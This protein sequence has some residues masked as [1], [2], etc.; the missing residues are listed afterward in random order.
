[1]ED[2]NHRAVGRG[3][4]PGFAWS[5]FWLVVVAGI[6][7]AVF[8]I[9]FGIGATIRFPATNYNIS[10]G[11]SLG[12]KDF[13]PQALPPYLRNQIAG[14]GTAFNQTNSVTIWIAEGIGML[15]IG[16]Q[17]Q[18]PIVDISVVINK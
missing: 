16:Y 13:A 12:K 8:N 17:P 1:M 18:A 11:L 15:V 7:L 14:N 4:R 6:A 2:N 3:Y 9:T 5:F 10:A